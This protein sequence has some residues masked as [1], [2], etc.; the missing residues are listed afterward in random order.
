ML[1]ALGWIVLS[2]VVGALCLISVAGW[3]LVRTEVEDDE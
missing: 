2:V 3:L 1:N